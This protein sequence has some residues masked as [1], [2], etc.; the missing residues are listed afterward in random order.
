M[1]VIY[2]CPWRE[3]AERTHSVAVRVAAAVGIQQQADVVHAPQAEPASEPCADDVQRHGA[4][5]RERCAIEDVDSMDADSSVRDR[6]RAHKAPAR[7]RFSDYCS[8]RQRS[9]R[10]RRLSSAPRS[11]ASYTVR[12]G[13]QT[14]Y[15]RRASRSARPS[16]T[17]S[18]SPLS[19]RP[20]STLHGDAS[21]LLS[22]RCP[23]LSGIW[24]VCLL[25]L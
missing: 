20:D 7:P 13:A 10:P 4:S 15:T 8:R 22:V 24:T 6:S 11:R 2:R 18:R 14:P 1:N 25:I 5:L 19:T 17:A 12:R 3:T 21:S 16:T 9:R 23:R